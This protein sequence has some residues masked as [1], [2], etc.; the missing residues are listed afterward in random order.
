MRKY[1]GKADGAKNFGRTYRLKFYDKS[2]N[3]IHSIVS[4]ETNDW[5]GVRINFDIHQQTTTMCQEAVIQLYNL[6]EETQ[7]LISTA[8][9]VVLEAGYQLNSGIIYSGS[10]VN[11]LRLRVQPDF[12]YE[13]MCMDYEDQYPPISVQI[14]KGETPE[15]IIKKVAGAVKGLGVTTKNLKNLPTKVYNKRI[16][17]NQMEYT[18]ALQKVALLLNIRLWVTN[19]QIYALPNELN[20]NPEASVIEIDYTNGLIGSPVYNLANTGVNCTSMLNHRLVPSNLVQI[21]T[22]NPKVQIGEAKYIGFSQNELNRGKWII[23]TANHKGDNWEGDWE[24]ILQSY[25]Y[26]QLGKNLI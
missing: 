24:S 14:P 1:I 21:K 26:T 7:S 25:A 6:S 4:D 3:L 19:G 12:I 9:R 15:E 11:S 8:S 23:Y 16:N 17:I 2:L 5:T 20:N 13:M 22:K 18:Q 10:I